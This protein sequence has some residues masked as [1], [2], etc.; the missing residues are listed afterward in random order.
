MRA[1]PTAR[2]HR[3]MPHQSRTLPSARRPAAIHPLAWRGRV[4]SGDGRR[5]ARLVGWAPRADGG[6]TARVQVHPDRQGQGMVESFTCGPSKI[7]RPGRSSS[8]TACAASRLPRV[9]RCLQAARRLIARRPCARPLGARPSPPCAA[10]RD[11]AR[12]KCVVAR[13]GSFKMHRR[14]N[15]QRV[16]NSLG[17]RLWRRRK[18]CAV[19][20]QRSRAPLTRRWRAHSRRANWRASKRP[21]TSTGS[22]PQ[23]TATAR[24]RTAFGGSSSS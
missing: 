23:S 1:T 2:P 15:V 20:C 18:V 17:Q 12:G 7:S 19:G 21:Q 4:V 24:P 22:R 9:Y 13:F 8:C 14:R 11:R 5:S 16:S 10:A 3:R 6:A